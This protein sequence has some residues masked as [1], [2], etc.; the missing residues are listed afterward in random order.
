MLN[1]TSVLMT[2]GTSVTMIQC[3]NDKWTS[4]KMIQYYNDNWHYCY[5]D[6]VLQW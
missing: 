1:G 4:V 3:Y 6:T 5:N 2:N